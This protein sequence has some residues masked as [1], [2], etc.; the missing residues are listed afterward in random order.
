MQVDV[1]VAA[2]KQ[3]HSQIV[4]PWPRGPISKTAAILERMRRKLQTSRG[5]KSM[6]GE[7]RSL[8]RYS[9]RSSTDEGFGSSCCG[10]LT[11]YGANGLW[12]V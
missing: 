12:C 1:Y 2:G 4:S 11:K 7:R 5:G 3:K 10:V 8:N 6:P 9:D